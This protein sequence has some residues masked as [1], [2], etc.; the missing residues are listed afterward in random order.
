MRIQD[1]PTDQI[2]AA[3]LDEWRGAFIRGMYHESPMARW[4]RHNLAAEACRD[5]LPHWHPD[6]RPGRIYR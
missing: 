1:I 2:I 6:W 4:E 5:L 3:V